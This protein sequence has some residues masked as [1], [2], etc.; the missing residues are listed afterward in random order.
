M[1]EKLTN[2]T[3]IQSKDAVMRGIANTKASRELS[4]IRDQ[5]EKQDCIDV[6][7]AILKRTYRLVKDVAMQALEQKAETGERW[8]VE[9]LCNMF[10]KLY[11]KSTLSL[12][13]LHGLDTTIDSKDDMNRLSS[14]LVSKLL[15]TAKLS[16][17]DTKELVKLLSTISF[18]ETVKE[19]LLAGLTDEQVNKFATQLR[20]IK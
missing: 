10:C 12:I 15:S 20:L 18:N 6:G 17:S 19:S 5:Q 3:R 13:D 8:A 16:S 14:Q 4:D 1:K 11:D 2:N 9:L 7:N